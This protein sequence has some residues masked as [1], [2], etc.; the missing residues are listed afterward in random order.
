M[1][2]TFETGG[3]GADDVGAGVGGFAGAAGRA[4]AVPL[5]TPAGG[6]RGA[7][8]VGAAGVGAA[9]VGARTG[10]GGGG[11]GAGVAGGAGGSTAEGS[12]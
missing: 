1:A 2:A 11:G 5:A 12:A 9:G 10:S 4:E 6:G 8:G 3:D 7:A